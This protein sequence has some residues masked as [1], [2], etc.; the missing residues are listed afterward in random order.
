MRFCGY[1]CCQVDSLPGV[2]L[3]RFLGSADIRGL[4][5]IGL[6]LVAT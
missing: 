6:V 1:S 5:N 4:E 2:D 3:R